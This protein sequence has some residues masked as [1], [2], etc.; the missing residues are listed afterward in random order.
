M[1]YARLERIPPPSPYLKHY[2][3]LFLKK[4]G[5]TFCERFKLLEII[6]QKDFEKLVI[7][8]KSSKHFVEKLAQENS[9]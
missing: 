3:S 5:E 1:K 9:H 2:F 4:K 6:G 8:L 7:F